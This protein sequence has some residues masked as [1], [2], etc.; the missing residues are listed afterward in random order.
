MERQRPW[1]ILDW[2]TADESLLRRDHYRSQG[3]I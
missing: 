1:N 3:R 2:D